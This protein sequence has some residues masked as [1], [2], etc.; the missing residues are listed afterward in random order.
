MQ[1]RTRVRTLQVQGVA[2]RAHRPLLVLGCGGER[3]GVA[4]LEVAVWI[5][6]MV[7]QQ[8]HDVAVARLRRLNERC[9]VKGPAVHV[10][11]WLL[12][13]QTRHYAYVPLLRRR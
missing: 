13:Q 3:R 11:G 12:R 2:H 8:V 4:R 1:R 5:A 9:A 10:R 7:Q 6:A